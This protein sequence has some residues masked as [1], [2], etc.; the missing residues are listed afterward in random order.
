MLADTQCVVVCSVT[1]YEFYGD[2]RIKGD[3]NLAT[4]ILRSNLIVQQLKL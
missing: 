4:L 3:A 1:N 2:K